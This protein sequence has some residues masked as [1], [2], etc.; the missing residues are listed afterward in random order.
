MEKIKGEKEK[1][2]MKWEKTRENLEQNRSR[3]KKLMGKLTSHKNLM[4]QNA[5]Q[6]LPRT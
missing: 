2:G 1:H 3:I 6:R 4:I 5:L